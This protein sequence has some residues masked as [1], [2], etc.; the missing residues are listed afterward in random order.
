MDVETSFIVTLFGMIAA[1][2]VLLLFILE[3]TKEAPPNG[4]WK[5]IKEILRRDDRWI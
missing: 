1:F 2:T 4:F 5:F 3:F